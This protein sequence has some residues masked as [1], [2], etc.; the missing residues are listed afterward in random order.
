MKRRVCLNQVLSHTINTTSLKHLFPLKCIFW[1][2][3]T[4][5]TVKSW[6]WTASVWALA[7]LRHFLVTLNQHCI[8]FAPPQIGWHV[9]L[10]LHHGVGAWEEKLDTRRRSFRGIENHN[11]HSKEFGKWK[12][13][14]LQHRF[15]ASSSCLGL[16]KHLSG[17]WCCPVVMTLFCV[18]PEDAIQSCTIDELGELVC[19]AAPPARPRSST[20][21][22]MSCQW[23]KSCKWTKMSMVLLTSYLTLNLK[24]VCSRKVPVLSQFSVLGL[25]HPQ[26]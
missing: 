3:Q 13:Q 19:L 24:N 8:F 12:E 18:H 17:N 15:E 23:K 6:T 14:D 21:L 25:N 5:F 16:E 10:T 9:S 11:P 4:T 2:R 26:Y 7:C 22:W 20:K 1:L